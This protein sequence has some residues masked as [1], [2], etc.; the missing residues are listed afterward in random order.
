MNVNTKISYDREL[1]M[2]FYAGLNEENVKKY[3]KKLEDFDEID[4]CWTYFIGQLFGYNL[5]A[6]SDIPLIVLICLFP[7]FCITLEGVIFSEVV[8]ADLQTILLRFPCTTIFQMA[9][10]WW[11]YPILAFKTTLDFTERVSTGTWSQRARIKKK[12]KLL[13]QVFAD[14]IGLARTKFKL[15]Q[16]YL[17]I[18]VKE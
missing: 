10:I 8:Y 9:F 17:K 18:S 16:L 5:T 4:L 2:C 13:A 12:K 14:A 6:P 11:S 1:C 7:Y 3:K 15:D